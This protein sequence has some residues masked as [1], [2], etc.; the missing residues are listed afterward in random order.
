MLW[1]L[2]GFRRL[3]RIIA[4]LALFRTKLY[5]LIPRVLWA[6]KPDLSHWVID[7]AV[8]QVPYPLDKTYRLYLE[9]PNNYN[10]YFPFTT[11]FSQLRLTFIPTRLAQV[12]R[13]ISL[14]DTRSALSTKARPYKV[15]PNFWFF[16]FPKPIRPCLLDFNEC[17]ALSSRAMHRNQQ[18]LLSF[19]RLWELTTRSH[20]YES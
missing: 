5:L 1:N 3:A 11:A 20:V 10:N 4:R 15:P 7:I 12:S 14:F 18:T 9:G 6:L 16:F 19:L 2:C 17:S 13:N 8:P